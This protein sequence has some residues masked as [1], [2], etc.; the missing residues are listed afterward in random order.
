MPEMFRLRTYLKAL[1]EDSTHIRKYILSDKFDH[2]VYQI[3]LEEK[4]RYDLLDADLSG[5]GK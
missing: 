1:E 2:E 3:N 4:T 5:F